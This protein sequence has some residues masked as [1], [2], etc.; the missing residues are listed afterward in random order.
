MKFDVHEEGVGTTT[1]R[2]G[3][4]SA[5]SGMDKEEMMK[6]V[7]AA[8]TPGVGHEALEAFEGDWNVEVKSWMDP[9]GPADT[10]HGKAKV[11][12]IF[13]GRFLEEEFHGQMMGK[14]FTGRGLFGFDNTKQK[15]NSVWIDDVN[16]AMYT[17][18]GK[19][20]NGNKIITLEGKASCAA[21]GQ[22]DVPMKQIF[23]VLGPDKHVLEM[24]H[25]GRKAM[26]ITYTR[27]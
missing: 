13:E 11:R 27:Q 17:S 18:E 19:G 3:D 1:R 16:T 20:E 10:S 25:D 22:K 4:M 24:F 5:K 9:S 15:F 21:S 2:G 6:R 26:E 8:G 14:P 23:R 12:W 7:Q